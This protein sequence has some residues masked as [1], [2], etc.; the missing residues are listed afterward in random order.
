VYVAAATCMDSCC[1]HRSGFRSG[2][3][4]TEGFGWGIHMGHAAHSDDCGVLLAGLLSQLLGHCGLAPHWAARYW[5]ARFY[6]AGSFC[7]VLARV[8]STK[9][10]ALSQV[11]EQF[12]VLSTFSGITSYQRHQLTTARLQYSRCSF[13]TYCIGRCSSNIWPL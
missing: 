5:V 4:S 1:C 13:S 2:V 7:C 6:A 10:C 3:L 11:L 9:H 12:R 8:G